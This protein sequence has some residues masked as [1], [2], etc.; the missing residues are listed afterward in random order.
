[1]ASGFKG[2]FKFSGLNKGSLSAYYAMI[3]ELQK[4]DAHLIACVTNR[5]PG[6]AD[7]NFY[8]EVTTRVIGGNINRR[9]LVGVLMD[10]IST[11]QGVGLDDVVR[12]RVN[13]WFNA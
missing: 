3:E 9:E 8:A 2:E 13:K 12:G 6:K 4:S 5:P 11:P 10:T 7:W 1:D